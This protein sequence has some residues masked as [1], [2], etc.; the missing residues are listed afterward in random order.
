MGRDTFVLAKDDN[1]WFKLLVQ[2]IKRQ[3]LA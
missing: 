1:E 3:E 2:F